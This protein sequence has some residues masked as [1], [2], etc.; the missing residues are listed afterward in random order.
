MEAGEPQE[1]ASPGIKSQAVTIETQGL[2]LVPV[3]V[4]FLVYALGISRN[5]L[6]QPT[7]PSPHFQTKMPGRMDRDREPSKNALVMFWLLQ[8]ASFTNKKEV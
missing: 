6:T 4:D 7:V 8:L 2:D 5:K 1:H 3:C